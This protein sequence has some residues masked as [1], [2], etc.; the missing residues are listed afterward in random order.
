MIRYTQTV[1]P[2]TEPIAADDFREHARLDDNGDD[3]TLTRMV[4]S[5]RKRVEEM[6][7]RAIVT[8]TWTATLDRW[9]DV[10]PADQARIDPWPFY[11]AVTTRRFRLSPAPIASI[12]SL[13]VDGATIASGNYR[14]SGD[15]LTVKGDVADSTNELG[16]GIVVTFVAGYGAASAAPD[17]LVEAI[18]MLA[19][20]AYER[21]G[22]SGEALNVIPDGAWARIEQY[23][24]IREF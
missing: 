5:A 9:A 12:T 2:A 8:Q 4:K 23:R 1:A 24:Q 15:E 7:H 3:A 10:D 16:G 22:E 6:T 17:G 11:T 19:T 14:L 20:E 21:R 13:V 18:L